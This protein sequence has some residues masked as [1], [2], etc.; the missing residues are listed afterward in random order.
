[1]EGGS[2]DSSDDSQTHP[3]EPLAVAS[4]GWSLLLPEAAKAEHLKY[5]NADEL[6]FQAHMNV[7]A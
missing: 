3:F 2:K 6:I 1:L 5:G 7:H 4:E